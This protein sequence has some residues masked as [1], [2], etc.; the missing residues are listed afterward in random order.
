MGDP[1]DRPP[2]GALS[3]QPLSLQSFPQAQEVFFS[4]P[5]QISSCPEMS[6]PE[7]SC[8][9]CLF[10]SPG[11]R[12]LAMAQWVKNQT[13]LAWVTAEAKVQSLARDLP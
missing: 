4:L 6:C 10:K 8:P 3:A 12:V 2:S 13:A 7:M 5:V 11:V 9:L 1:G